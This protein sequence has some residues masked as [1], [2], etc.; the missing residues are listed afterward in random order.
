MINVGGEK[1][2]FSDATGEYVSYFFP[3]VFEVKICKL[4]HQRL[5]VNFRDGIGASLV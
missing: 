2:V 4:K 3:P 5:K 1:Q